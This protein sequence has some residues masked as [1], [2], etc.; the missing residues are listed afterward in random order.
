MQ[1]NII[2]F[3]PVDVDQAELKRVLILSLITDRRTA[4]MA[5]NEITKIAESNRA[6]RRVVRKNRESGTPILVRN[7]EVI[8]ARIAE[9]KNRSCLWK[10]LLVLIGHN[11]RSMADDIDRL[12]PT[13]VLLDILEVNQT[14]RTCLGDKA[15]IREIV[16]VKGLEDSATNRHSDFKEGPLFRAMMAYM[17][18]A[19]Y[20]NPELRKKMTDSLFGKGGMFEFVPTYSLG[21][22]GKMHRNQPNLRL[23][24]EVDLT[25]NPIRH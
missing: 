4:R 15:T 9:R 22:D 10:E 1:T 18:H 13:S 5:I 11:I 8:E 23:A 16:F 12:I 6:D 14:D 25:A 17:M 21:S 3:A 2:K 20:T 19:M 7:A 24:D